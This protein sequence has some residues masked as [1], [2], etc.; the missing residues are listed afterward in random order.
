MHGINDGEI[1]WVDAGEGGVSDEEP[2]RGEEAR[3]HRGE[4]KAVPGEKPETHNEGR[5]EEKR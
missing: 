4:G 2:S 5:Q 3:E 1:R